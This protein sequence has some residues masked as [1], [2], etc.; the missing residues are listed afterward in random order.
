[1]ALVIDT[2]EVEV[3]LLHP[4]LGTVPK[5]KEVYAAF[6]ATKAAAHADKMNKKGIGQFESGAPTDDPDAVAALQAE[7]VETVKDIEEKGWTGFMQDDEGPFLYDYVVKGFLSEAARTIKE[8][9]NVK[10][11]QDKVKRY[12]FVQPRRVRLPRPTAPEGAAGEPALAV[13]ERPLRAQTAMGPRVTVVRSDLM[14][15]E[16]TIRFTLRVIKGGG[17]TGSILRD[18][19]SYGEFQGLGQ[20][21]TG[22]WGRFEVVTFKKTGTT[23]KG[24]S[25]PVEGD[26]DEEEDG[27]DA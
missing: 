12:C 9:G 18:V 11:L 24:K 16:T 20:W 7:E 27:E 22:G 1:M 5:R 25:A 19:L 8:S 26:D 2:Y 17:L 4:M 10:Q 23:G 14:P 21:R 6:I 3:R 15:E 13:L